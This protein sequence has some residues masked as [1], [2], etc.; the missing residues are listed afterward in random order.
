M[1]FK[2]NLRSCGFVRQLLFAV[3]QQPLQ[4][5]QGV[6]QVGLLDLLSLACRHHSA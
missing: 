4:K 2:R 6:V 5:D 3:F 1:T